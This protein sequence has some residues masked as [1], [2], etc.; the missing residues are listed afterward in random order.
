[1]QSNTPIS[2]IAG[3]FCTACQSSFISL[4]ITVEKVD[5]RAGTAPPPN[6]RSACQHYCYIMRGGNRSAATEH[7][8]VHWHSVESYSD[9]EDAQS[10]NPRAILTRAG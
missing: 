2:K 5:T 10:A 9:C 1:M 4:C 7:V 6:P 3:F 8:G